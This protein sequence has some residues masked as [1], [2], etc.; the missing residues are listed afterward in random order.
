MTETTQPVVDAEAT[1]KPVAEAN[2]NGAGDDL[3]TLLSQFE[4]ETKAAPSPAP[5]AAPQQPTVPPVDESRIRHIEERFL[6]EDIDKAVSNIF[7]DSKVNKRVAMGWLDQVAREKPAVANAFLN[8]HK[9]PETWKK[10]ERSLAKEAEKDFNTD[11]DTN[12]TVDV[13]AVSAAVRGASTKAPSE[14]APNYA[15][16]STQ[17]LRAEMIKLG[18]NPSF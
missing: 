9:D 7:G 1:A 12:A 5:V 10:I 17:E 15:S 18:I 11:I 6:K 2:T 3:D 13:A 14:Q 4:T 16:M 8:Q